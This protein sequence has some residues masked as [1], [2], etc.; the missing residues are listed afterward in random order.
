[1]APKT[2]LIVDDAKLTATLIKKNLQSIGHRALI[3]YSAEEALE[4][5]YT[6]VPDLIILDVVLPGMSGFELC[7]KL[8]RNP[9]YN[10]IPI[11]MITGMSEEDDRLKGLESGADDYIVKPFVSRELLARVTNTLNRIERVRNINPLSL[12]QGNQEI[13]NEIERRIESGRQFAMMYIDLNGFKAYNDVYGFS[14]GDDLI[15][16]TARILTTA[17]D[18]FGSPSDF[19]GHIGGDDFVIIA[20]PDVVVPIAQHII[21]CFDTDKLDYYN[22]EDRVRGYTISKNRKGL[23]ALYPLVGIAIAVLI[24]SNKEKSNA[25]ELTKAVAELK[26]EVKMLD[27]SAYLIRQD[28]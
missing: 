27:K 28:D 4:I 3:A 13:N 23:V 5:L 15:R 22:E 12:L 7:R 10:M 16:L 19:V 14:S 6:Y 2:I 17:V 26:K 8:R 25:R 1:M 9:R 24:S 20:E 18:K 21:R 11:I